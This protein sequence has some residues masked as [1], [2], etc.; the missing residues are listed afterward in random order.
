MGYCINE[1]IIATGV[2]STILEELELAIPGEVARIIENRSAMADGF[3]SG[4]FVLPLISWGRDLRMMVAQQAGY[5]IIS[6]KGFSPTSDNG[7]LWQLKKTEADNWLYNV[8]SGK[9]NP[10]G[11][12][13]SAVPATPQITNASFAPIINSEPLRGW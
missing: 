9:I 12:V 11:I 3:I 10:A 8:S 6:G 4:R 7:Q 1:D 13:D 5:D 2:S